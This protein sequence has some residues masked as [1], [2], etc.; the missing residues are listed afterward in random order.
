MDPLR[1]EALGSAVLNGPRLPLAIPKPQAPTPEAAAIAAQSQVL[2]LAQGWT[3]LQASAQP[4]LQVGTAVPA[5][6][7]A[8]PTQGFTTALAAALTPT[9]PA[10]PAASATTAPADSGTATPIPGTA[11]AAATT[12]PL[13]TST[14]AETGAS[15]DFALL[16][17]LRFGAGV[18]PLGAPALQGADLGATLVRDA[19]AVPRLPNLQPQPGR[20]GPEDFARLLQTQAP[21]AAQAVPAAATAAGLDLLA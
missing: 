9:Q 6:T 11:A 20:P 3:L 18:I 12:E 1:V 19:A 13:A 5:A 4:V 16:T 10:T 17:A 15:A 14:P 7:A 8:D 2:A 21:Q